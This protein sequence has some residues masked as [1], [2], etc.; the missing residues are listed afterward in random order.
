MHSFTGLHAHQHRRP[1][2]REEQ[3]LPGKAIS[4]AFTPSAANL[5]PFDLALRYESRAREKE[6]ERER[7]REREREGGRKKR[8]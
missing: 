8:I 2:G 5:T 4:R 3:Q 6:K 7:E 1:V